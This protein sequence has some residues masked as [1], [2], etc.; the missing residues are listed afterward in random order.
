MTFT[1]TPARLIEQRDELRRKINYHLMVIH[2]GSARL[3][4]TQFDSLV[5][6]LAGDSQLDVDFEW[7]IKAYREAEVT[8]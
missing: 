7:L 5:A 3:S 8:L 4:I 2:H 6:V 1:Q